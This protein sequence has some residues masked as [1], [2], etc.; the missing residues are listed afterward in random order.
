MVLN[1]IFSRYVFAQLSVLLLLVAGHERFQ[2]RLDNPPAHTPEVIWDEDN[3]LNPTEVTAPLQATI[4]LV[5]KDMGRVEGEQLVLQPTTLAQYRPNLCGDV[6]FRSEP[7]PGSCSGVLI[8]PQIIATAAHCASSTDAAKG[9]Y[10]VFGFNTAEA[11]AQNRQVN[12]IPIKDVYEAKEV[13]GWELGN[14][15]TDD[16]RSSDWALIRLE[17]KVENRAPVHVRLGGKTDADHFYV[18]G[19]PSGLPAKVTARTDELDR[20]SMMMSNFYDAFF[21][22][23]LD[24]FG[25]NSGSPVFN[26]VTDELEGLLV[27]GDSD[28]MWEYGSGQRC[29]REARCPQDRGQTGIDRGVLSCSGET[30]TRATE[31]SGLLMYDAVQADTSIGRTVPKEVAPDSEHFPINVPDYGRG[32]IALHF[33]SP[34]APQSDETLRTVGVNLEASHSYSIAELSLRLE[35]PTGRSVDFGPLPSS[36]V[37]HL[38]ASRPEVHAAF[39]DSPTGT[40]TLYVRD[41]AAQDTGEIQGARLAFFFSDGEG[42]AV[43]LPMTMSN[44]VPVEI[45]DNR[46][47]GV[48]LSFNPVEPLPESIATMKSPGVVSWQLE[49]KLNHARPRDAVQMR[50][51]SPNNDRSFQFRT[52]TMGTERVFGNNNRHQIFYYGT[53][54]LGTWNVNL[55][56]WNPT[57][58]GEVT[59][60]TLTLKVTDME[61]ARVSLRTPPRIPLGEGEGEAPEAPEGEPSEAPAAEGEAE[62]E[63]EQMSTPAPPAEEEGEGH[64]QMSTPPPPA[65]TPSPE[66]EEVPASP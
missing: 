10:Y 13:I 26:A 14:S 8:S 34:K 22:A 1:R 65:E 53:N 64:G 32:Q 7:A 47:Q 51:G 56:D 50:L 19:H 4:V 62:G 37:H 31:F 61:E 20:Q 9:F 15:H 17:R 5:R 44:P 25:G 21:R 48:D 58:V 11:A 41:T 63:H 18:I 46:Y 42:D 29:Q 60:A 6:S 35:G 27:R 38:G 54:P 3:R 33:E 28:W 12:R 45:P 16:L 2:L 30:V 40:W 66:A 39:G 55:V 36:P 59:E 52:R 23:R 49:L 57:V 43:T 24:T